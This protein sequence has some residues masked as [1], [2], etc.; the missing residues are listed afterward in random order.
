LTHPRA[1]PARRSRV[2]G[3]QCSHCHGWDGKGTPIGNDLTTGMY[4]WGDGS[5]TT[6]K[7]TVL[8][9]MTM[10][11]GMDGDLKAADVE[12]VAAYIWALGRRNP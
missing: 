9:N 12:A 7:R 4:I 10:A 2:S 1:D 5:V 8:H 6:I 3:G 11:P